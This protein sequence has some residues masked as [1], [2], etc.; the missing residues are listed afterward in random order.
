M[1]EEKSLMHLTR[2]Q[3]AMNASRKN[4]TSI[5]PS[6]CSVEELFGYKLNESGGRIALKLCLE[7]N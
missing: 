3:K 7:D 1:A 5:W 6:S 2:K 4:R